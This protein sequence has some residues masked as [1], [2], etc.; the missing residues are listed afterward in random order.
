MN[1]KAINKL[2]HC[3]GLEPYKIEKGKYEYYRNF[4]DAGGNDPD[5][6]EMVEQGYA[7]HSAPNVYRVTPAGIKFLEDIMSI[8]IVKQ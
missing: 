6:E 8:R 4:Y 2:K 7:E 3:I 1:T 5:L